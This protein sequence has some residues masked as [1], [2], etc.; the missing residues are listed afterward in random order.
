MLKPI[1]VLVVDDSALMRSLICSMLS[2]DR[3]IKVI[4][5]ARDGEE[6]VEK[7]LEKRPDV[8]TLDVEMPCLN[9]L[10]ALQIIMKEA[11]TRVIML[12]GINEPEIT[13]EALSQGAVDF[14]VKPSG[15]FSIDIDELK[16]ELILKVKIAA[17]VRLATL[18]SP[19]IKKSSKEKPLRILSVT[20]RAVAIGASTGGPKALERIFADLP[21]DLPAPIMIVQHLPIGFSRAFAERLASVGRLP[22]KEAENG[23]VLEAGL[24]FVA[25]A[26]RHMLITKNGR[27]SC[28]KL[29]DGPRVW[30]VKPS[31]DKL[32][33]SVAE[34]FGSNSIGVVLTGMGVDGAAGVKAIKEKKGTVIVQDE[35]TSVVFGMAKAAIQKKAVDKVVPVN[36]IGREIIQAIQSELSKD[37][38]KAT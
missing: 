21:A 15:T 19:S 24:V 11:P 18:K 5:I 37:T 35:K 32:M 38:L 14:V 27:K 31:A 3:W 2:S 29:E 30:G 26:G 22:V 34:V 25:P 33:Q 8:I 23:D 20:T 17:G 28:I 7:A 16:D 12:S 9:G 10:K 4:D 1:R 36:K 6:A 13:Y